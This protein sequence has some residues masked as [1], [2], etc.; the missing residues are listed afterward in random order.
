M[1]SV[2]AV[3]V[4]NLTFIDICARVIVG[5]HFEAHATAALVAS[6]SVDTYLITAA[7]TG[8]ALVNIVT[9]V[10]ITVQ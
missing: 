8:Q 7:I 4:V 10:F 6:P 2:A 1:T 9:L 3:S 5:G